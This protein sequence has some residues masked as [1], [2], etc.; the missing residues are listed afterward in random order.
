M[1][2]VYT[3]PDETPSSR[4]SVVTLRM[5]RCR[6]RRPGADELGCAFGGITVHEHAG[7]LGDLGDP[8]AARI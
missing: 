3:T 7:K 8:A 6:G 2:A 4:S 1:A 5:K